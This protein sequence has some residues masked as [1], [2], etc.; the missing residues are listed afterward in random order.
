MA[1]FFK[2]A[3]PLLMLIGI[4][5]LFSAHLEYP[6][7]DLS[8]YGGLVLTA[9]GCIM[10]CV[11]FF[12]F[13]RSGGQQDTL[14]FMSSIKAAKLSRT[15][16]TQGVL[17]ILVLGSV[18]AIEF[19]QYPIWSIIVTTALFLLALIHAVIFKFR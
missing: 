13:W 10:Y 2:I 1:R 14:D 16:V 18:F 9:L 7:H 17:T 4:A 6:F 19:L 12:A 3:G 11:Y 15:R 5:L 8:S